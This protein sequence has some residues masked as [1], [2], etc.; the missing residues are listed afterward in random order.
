MYPEAALEMHFVLL[1]LVMNLVS[2]S[3]DHTN[4]WFLS[5]LTEFSELRKIF[6]E[7]SNVSVKTCGPHVWSP[8][9]IKISCWKTLAGTKKWKRKLFVVVSQGRATDSDRENIELPR[10]VNYGSADEL[11]FNKEGLTVY[12]LNLFFPNCQT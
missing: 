10:Q 9:E 2:D 12:S 6:S 7:I 11:V 3:S 8:N 5:W 1:P 4:F